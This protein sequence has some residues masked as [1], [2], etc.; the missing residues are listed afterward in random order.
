M[1]TDP[2]TSRLL[3]DAPAG[4]SAQSQQG[5]APLRS[6]RLAGSARRLPSRPASSAGHLPS[7]PASSARHLPSRPAG[8]ARRLARS[9]LSRGHSFSPILF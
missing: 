2:L 8:G 3:E 7:R 6:R 4:R 5:D 9:Y 1:S